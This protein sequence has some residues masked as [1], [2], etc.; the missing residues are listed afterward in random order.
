MRMVLLGTALQCAF[1]SFI[2]VAPFL[3][4]SDFN[5]S[6]SAYG[7]YFTIIP[8]GF[9]IGSLI[10]GRWSML[11]GN[12]S[13]VW[14]G[15]LAAG[16]ACMFAWGIAELEWF[17]VWGFFVPISLLALSQGA[18]MPSVQVLMLSAAEPNASIG[19][20]LFSAFQLLCGAVVAQIA[21]TLLIY[22]SAGITAFMF[23]ICLF[24]LFFASRQRFSSYQI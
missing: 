6:I 2:A 22:G 19:S 7:V 18:A 17:G 10:A 3:L 11:L 12:N 21:G 9:F 15:T 16:I 5:Q 8:T 4:V 20:G 1:I 24:G 14:H 23:I 13:L